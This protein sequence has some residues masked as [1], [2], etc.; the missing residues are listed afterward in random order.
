MPVGVAPL[1][2][3]PTVAARPLSH[4]YYFAVTDEWLVFAPVVV[5]VA[6]T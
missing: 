5:L 3:T 4:G 6:R 2:T 1:G